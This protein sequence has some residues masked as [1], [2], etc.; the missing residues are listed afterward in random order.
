MGR[1]K[2]ELNYKAGGIDRNKKKGQ[3]IIEIVNKR[4]PKVQ[5]KL[6]KWTKRIESQ[7][8]WELITWIWSKIA[9]VKVISIN[10]NCFRIKYELKCI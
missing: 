2:I 6:A 3:W 9:Y 5:I 4:E 7:T 8:K 1:T 10:E